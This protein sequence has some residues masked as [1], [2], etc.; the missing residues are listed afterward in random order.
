MTVGHYSYC[1]AL[2]MIVEPIFGA[3]RDGDEEIIHDIYCSGYLSADLD[4]ETAWCERVH[5]SMIYNTGKIIGNT[6]YGRKTFA[7]SVIR[8][9]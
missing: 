8:A 9:G 5:C 3:N 6:D 2:P 1:P 7:V 4:N